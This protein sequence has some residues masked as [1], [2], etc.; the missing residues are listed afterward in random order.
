MTT[1]QMHT[2]FEAIYGETARGTF[3][4]YADAR[5]YIFAKVQVNQTKNTRKI[6]MISPK[7][8]F[9]TTWGSVIK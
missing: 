7:G 8:V 1:T 4:S 2:V 9:N 6:W 5:D 3:F